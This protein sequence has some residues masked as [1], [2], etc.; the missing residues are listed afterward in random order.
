MPAFR[1]PIGMHS[2]YRRAHG[3]CR[4][5]G[6]PREPADIPAY[7]DGWAPLPPG[8]AAAGCGGGARQADGKTA[9]GGGGPTGT[10]R[11]ANRRPAVGNVKTCAPAAVQ[12]GHARAL[13]RG[14]AFPNG[15]GPFPA[16]NARGRRGLSPANGRSAAPAVTVPRPRENAVLRRFAAA[17]ARASG[18]AASNA[19]NPPCPAGQPPRAA[20]RTPVL[21]FI[22]LGI[23]FSRY[24]ML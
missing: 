12:T 1:Y 10:G 9:D 5:G 13:R 16:A 6:V 20:T 7:S 24:T 15:S 17:V 21:H 19:G 3:G 11:T 4:S 23:G 2:P 14:T 8:E 22:G 18:R